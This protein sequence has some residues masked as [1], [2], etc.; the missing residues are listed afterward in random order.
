[1]TIIP[2]KYAAI[3]RRVDL[4]ERRRK[5]REVWVWRE[6]HE[7]PE[8]AVE[9]HLLE[10]PQ[11]EGCEFVVIGWKQSAAA[12]AVKPSPDRSAGL[13]ASAR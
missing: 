8:Q 10:E 11:D 3:A 4:A 13:C 7:L 6:R 1:M 12:P 9:R 5:P 2:G